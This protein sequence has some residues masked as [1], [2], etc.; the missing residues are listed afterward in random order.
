MKRKLLFAIRIKTMSAYV[1]SGLI[2]AYII[3]GSLYSTFKHMQFV[4]N[5]PFIFI[6]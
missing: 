5:M 1:F 6:L 4:S 2:L 3:L